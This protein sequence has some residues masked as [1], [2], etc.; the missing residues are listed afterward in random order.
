MTKKPT[1]KRQ[2]HWRYKKLGDSYRRP[3]GKLSKRRRYQARKPAMARV[4]YRSPKSTRGLHPSGFKDI[5]VSNVE[6]IKALNP[7]T[8]AARISATVGNRKRQ[9]IVAEAKKLGV[10]IL[11]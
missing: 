7:E 1:F 4:G 10:K 9:L 2:E 5:L 6:E 3:R 11:N 8:D